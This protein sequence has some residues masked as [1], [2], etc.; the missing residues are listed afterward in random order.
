MDADGAVILALDSRDV[1][2]H[3]LLD[4]RWRYWNRL[5]RDGTLCRLV[6]DTVQGA[7]AGIGV[8]TLGQVHLTGVKMNNNSIGLQVNHGG[9][10]VGGATM[11]GNNRGIHMVAG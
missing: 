7:G 1:T 9:T 6:N 4:Q 2:N 11:H 10:V 3:G 8:F 5:P